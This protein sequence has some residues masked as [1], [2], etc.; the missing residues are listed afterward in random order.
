MVSLNFNS[1]WKFLIEHA[2]NFRL[3]LILARES[4]KTRS[5]YYGLSARRHSVA[6]S[7]SMVGR[8]GAD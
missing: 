4:V 3:I 8:Y 5:S 1:I 7:V 2:R 6:I